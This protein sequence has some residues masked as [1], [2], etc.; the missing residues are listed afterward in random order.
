M[1]VLD[2]FE[3][4]S[5]ASESK[6]KNFEKKLSSNMEVKIETEK[7]KIQ[8]QYILK[9]QP[10]T[11][12]QEMYQDLKCNKE[13]EVIDLQGNSVIDTSIIG[14][15]YK[16]KFKDNTEY[17]MIVWGDFTGDGKISVAELARASRIAVQ[18][19]ELGLREKLI[20]DVSMDGNIQI[21]D[22]AAICRLALE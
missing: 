7:Y 5:D 14:T 8:D 19:N 4:Y 3:L 20:I 6:L 9:I 10:G 16:I 13:F 1:D 17:T 2:V 18:N 15:G 11:T 12:I 22:L 21:A